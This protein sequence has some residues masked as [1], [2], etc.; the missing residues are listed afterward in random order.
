MASMMRRGIDEPRSRSA[1]AAPERGLSPLLPLP[2]LPL[3][4]PP[5]TARERHSLDGGFVVAGAGCCCSLGGGV[6]RPTR[7][8]QTLPLPSAGRGLGSTRPVL[9]PLFPL[10]LP[11]SPRRIV[12]RSRH[13]LS[14]DWSRCTVPRS[15]PR[16][17]PRSFDE[18]VSRRMRLSYVGAT[19]PA[20]IGA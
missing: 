14:G 11:V 5:R 13:E 9:L 7:S 16:S 4:L 3:P 2:L 20:P 10:L 6:P 19:L 12:S 17:L 8:R 18:G 1:S 15:L